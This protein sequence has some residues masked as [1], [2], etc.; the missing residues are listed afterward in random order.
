MIAAVQPTMHDIRD[1][2]RQLI[3]RP[4]FALAI[5]VTIGLGSGANALVFNV[6]R[7]VLLRPLPFSDADQLV[8]IWET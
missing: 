8:A 6:V 7:A 5:M 4:A 2:V 1:A 3:H